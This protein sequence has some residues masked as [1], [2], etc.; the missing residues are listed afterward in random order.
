ME[1]RRVEYPDRFF[2]VYARSGA[3]CVPMASNDYRFVTQWRVRGDISTVYTV[4][5]DARDYVRWW[6]DVYLAIEQDTE[7]GPDGLGAS[8]VLFTKGWLPYRLRW[9]YTTIANDP[10]HGFTIEASGDFVGTGTWTLTPDGDW[11]DVRFVWDVR[12]D[13][14]LLRGLS[15]LLKPVFTANHQWAMRRGKLRLEEELRR[16]RTAKGAASLV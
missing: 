2:D 8:G 4:L 10:P 12:A 7:P 13:K 9:R 1:T 5:A 11:T 3:H 15:W 6:P 14:P 16:L